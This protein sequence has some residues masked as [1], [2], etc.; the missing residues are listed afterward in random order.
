[1]WPFRRK[2]KQPQD[3]SVSQDI[4][5]YYQSESKDSILRIWLLSGAT[6]ILTLLIILGIFWGGRILYRQLNKST[7]QQPL[8]GSQP[9]RS[10]GQTSKKATNNSDSDSTNED[11][12]KLRSTETQ[13]ST[14]APVTPP[15]KQ[16][17]TGPSSSSSLIDTGPGDIDL[18]GVSLL[19]NYL[20]AVSSFV[21]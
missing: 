15:V 8:S 17:T 11:S 12:D 9:N 13:L 10:S 2:V 18:Q 4:K 6:F 14:P 3:S 19:N 1:M 7:T 16:P 21:S 5:A 20:S